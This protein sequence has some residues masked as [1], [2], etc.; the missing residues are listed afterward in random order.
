MKTTIIDHTGIVYKGIPQEPNAT[1]ETH[2]EAFSKAY[3]H[4]AAVTSKQGRLID[5]NDIY[6][7][8]TIYHP[9]TKKAVKIMYDTIETVFKEAGINLKP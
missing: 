4:I 6:G 3:N 2:P 8:G 7:D 1:P 5:F 9:L